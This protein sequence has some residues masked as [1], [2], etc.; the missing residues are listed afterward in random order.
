MNDKK[1][2]N[3]FVLDTFVS[4]GAPE[5][6]AYKAKPHIGTDILV[7]VVRK[8]RDHIIE[9]GGCFMFDTRMTGIE[10]DTNGIHAVE[11]EY[12]GNQKEG[13]IKKRKDEEFVIPEGDADGRIRIETN[14]VVLAIGHSARDTFEM[15][16]SRGIDMVQKN[17]AVGLRLLP[18]GGRVSVAGAG[19]GSALDVARHI[20]LP[21]IVL[22]LI[23]F[24]S[25]TRY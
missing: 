15:L 14:C 12:T 20:V 11:A 22:S 25:W 8:M 24:A 9:H 17:F 16:H 6:I 19:A 5:E 21:A 2:R 3:Q 23:Y 4:F 7:K 1:G 13:S 18:S 10:C